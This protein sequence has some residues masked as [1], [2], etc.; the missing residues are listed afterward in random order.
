MTKA[1]EVPEKYKQIIGV[2]PFTLK[3]RLM[4]CR[5]PG[6]GQFGILQRYW[7]KLQD[8]KDTDT[9]GTMYMKVQAMTLDIMDT[10]FLDPADRDWMEEQVIS[11]TVELEDL[12]PMLSGGKTSR[13]AA[14]DAEVEVAPKSL[15]TKKPAET[16]PV[17][18][19]ANA[20]RTRS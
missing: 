14:D 19:T 2:F 20:K 7:K 10:Q 13:P 5:L 4:W 9:Y 6:Q 8:A 1:P 15:R 12:M 17:K 16:V 3:G 11:R 18:K